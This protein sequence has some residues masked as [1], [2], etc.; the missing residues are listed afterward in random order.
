[1]N[2]EMVLNKMT[3]GNDDVITKAEA[4]QCR[5]RL[6]KRWHRRLI[7]LNIVIIAV[8]ICVFVSHF[9][10]YTKKAKDMINEGI[11]S[12]SDTL[13]GKTN[14]ST[15]EK[16]SGSHDDGNIPWDVK[17]VIMGIGGIFS[18]Y[19]YMT[20]M[21]AKNKASALKITEQNFPEVYAI[22]CEQARKLGMKKVPEVY[23]IQANGVLNAFSTFCLSKQYI[24]VNAEI[25]EVAYREH[26][27]LDSLSFII[28]HE[29]S[30]IYFGHAKLMYNLGI[31]FANALPVFGTTASRAREYSCDR[32]AQ[33]I[34]GND[35]IDSMF[36]LMVDRH[37]YKMVDK[38]DYIKNAEEQKGL[39]LWVSNLLA[40]HPVA[41]KRIPA[42]AMG[43]GSGKLY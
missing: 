5:H 32:L 39:F 11:Q 22:V 26:H 12:I 41:C 30:H 35:G 14:S 33:R 16:E 3:M 20:Y 2:G 18:I 37:I 27:D 40:D 43:E 13:E 21:Y 15:E 19:I 28:A 31:L 7:E 1:M 8:V 42:L 36:M 17:A 9:G 24:T 10:N 23:V 25:F 38:A 34:T 29:M 6:E 4:E